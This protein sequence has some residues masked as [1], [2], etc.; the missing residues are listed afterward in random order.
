MNI[1]NEEAED[2]DYKTG[3]II[4][5]KF[6]IERILGVGGMGAV[7]AATHV[8]LGELQAIKFLL[9]GAH[10][11]EDATKRFMREARAA[12][13]LR[14]RHVCKVHDVAKLASGE[15]Y[16]VM[17]YLD[18]Q[19]LKSFSQMSQYLSHVVVVDLMMQV[20]EALAEAHVNGIVH[21]DLKPANLFVVEDEDGLPSA[22]VLD[23]GISK[24]TAQGGATMDMTKTSTMMGSPY[25]MSPE[26]MRSTR[27]VD[28]RTDIWALGVIL[29][30]LL[31]GDVPFKGGSVT[32][33]CVIVLQDEPEPPSRRGGTAML[34]PGLDDVVL[35]CLEKDRDHRYADVGEMAEALAPFGTDSATRS[36]ARVLRAQERGPHSERTSHVGLE[37]SGDPVGLANT[38]QGTGDP[39]NDAGEHAALTDLTKVLH[40]P[41]PVN[42]S[43]DSGTVS[44]APTTTPPNNRLAILIAGT[45][46]FAIF[47]FIAMRNGVQDGTP[48]PSP[49]NAATAPQNVVASTKP[50]ASTSHPTPAQAPRLPASTVPAATARAPSISPV[51]DRTAA[52]PAPSVPVAK[53]SPP[54][55]PTAPARASAAR[56]KPKK[57]TPAPRP[58]PKPVPDPFGDGRQ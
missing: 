53:P 42:S 43:T 41:E 23:F 4:A 7:V 9:P 54:P 8:D 14:S 34:P 37:P 39:V 6:R 2:L 40:R 1:V 48:P 21:R 30:E 19:D 56:P 49:S 18:G 10:E 24:V 16:M 55:G 31:T 58:A 57:P 29:Y 44:P 22:K 20:L 36:L 3:D 50:T 35:R 11:D 12:A 15:P 32:E 17:E 33:Q 47:A 25:Y 27:D 51:A 45:V 38:A 46:V 28:A 52:A 5:G 26:Q 13:R